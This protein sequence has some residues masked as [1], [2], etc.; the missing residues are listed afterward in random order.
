[1]SE[2]IEGM[3][4][5]TLE[6]APALPVAQ[7]A[8]VAGGQLAAALAQVVG[9]MNRVPKNG[10]NSFHKYDYA[11]ESDIMDA[12]RAELAKVGVAIFPSV[13]EVKVGEADPKDRLGPVTT[14]ELLVT[15]VHESGEA[16]TTRWYGQGQDKT[17]K[18]YYKAYTGAMKYCLLKTFLMSTGDDP[19]ASDGDG[20]PTRASAS[21]PSRPAPKPVESR[22]PRVWSD[23]GEWK[24]LN[25]AIRA[26]LKPC[27][28]ADAEKYLEWVKARVGVTS[29]T[30]IP[31]TR[32]AK[33]LEHL[34]SL[35]DNDA[36]VEH[37]REVVP[38][39]EVAA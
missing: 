30:H 19:E 23:D 39:E 6:A 11:T 18:G 15:F 2:K 16:M 8:C 26:S 10:R 20:Q 27:G 12:V 21:R 3:I 7:G 37:V 17:D 13:G 33:V 31:P 4:S 35:G 32:L 9:A 14:V 1:M 34:G 36:I 24:R 38:R 28:K 29:L 22:E 5:E 25:K